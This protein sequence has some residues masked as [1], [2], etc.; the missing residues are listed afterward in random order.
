MY[1]YGENWSMVM[2]LNQQGDSLWTRNF[3]DRKFGNA[4]AL[5]NG[6]VCLASFKNEKPYTL[7]LNSNG[8]SLRSAYIADTIDSICRYECIDSRLTADN[9]MIFFINYEKFVT[10]MDPIGTPRICMIKTDYMGNAI[11]E[12]QAPYS[13]SDM[14]INNDGSMLCSNG[15]I[16]NLS[17]TGDITNIISVP[18]NKGA[19][20]KMDDGSYLVGS[21]KLFKVDAS[22]NV[23]WSQNFLPDMNS[24]TIYC[25]KLINNHDNTYTMF[26]YIGGGDYWTAIV[27]RFRIG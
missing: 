11:W 27:I 6:E 15:Y 5:S 10:I 19:V 22:G 13:F 7:F 3:T 21:S 1:I 9:E 12:R 18:S 26:G 20:V 17:P 25:H 24:K 14:N 8:D 4:K 23:L 2:K 16:F